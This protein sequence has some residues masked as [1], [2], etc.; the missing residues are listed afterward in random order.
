MMLL[1]LMM[2]IIRLYFSPGSVD[3]RLTV[4]LTDKALSR[5]VFPN[6]YHCLGDNENRPVKWLALEALNF[7]IFSPAS[8]T[9]RHHRQRPTY[10]HT[11]IHAHV[12]IFMH[13]IYMYICLLLYSGMFYSCSCVKVRNCA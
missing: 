5:D 4:R 2:I 10:T 12:K 3:S 8:D 1:L 11:H 7:R 6:E 9:V 13:Y